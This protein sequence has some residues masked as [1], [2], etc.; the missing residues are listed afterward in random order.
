MTCGK[1]VVNALAMSAYN[2]EGEWGK[3]LKWKPASEAAFHPR[4]TMTC[5]F[6]KLLCTS[7]LLRL[8]DQSK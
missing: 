7:R 2:R 5:M 8:E 4:V 3:R 6:C 1:V